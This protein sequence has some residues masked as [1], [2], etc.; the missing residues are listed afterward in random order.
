MKFVVIEFNSV[1]EATEFASVLE[2]NGMVGEF[3]R[4]NS[5]EWVICYPDETED[6]ENKQEV[7]QIMFSLGYIEGKDYIM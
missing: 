5:H 2:E 6:E 4:S 7:E 1:S 3:E